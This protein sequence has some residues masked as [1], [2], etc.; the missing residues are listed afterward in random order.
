MFPNDDAWEQAFTAWDGQIAG[1][2]NFQGK[3]ANDAETLAACLKFDEDFDRT[4]ER[5]GTYA[6]LK[7]SEDT[8]DSRYQRMQGRYLNVASRAAQAASYLRPEILAIPNARMKGFLASDAFAPYRLLLERLL[9]YKPHT[10]GRKR[11]SCWPCRP[12]WPRPPG[13]CFA[14]STTPT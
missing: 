4:G 7:T 12:R 10:L 1:Y 13:R 5:L 2:A 8:T 11:K 14:S 3:L 6:Q 9:R